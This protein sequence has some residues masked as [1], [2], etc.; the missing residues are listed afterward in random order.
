MKRIKFI[1]LSLI[2]V[3]NTVHSQA[4]KIDIQNG[5][6]ITIDGN[7]GFVKFRL[8]QNADEFL[9]KSY[10][11]NVTKTQNKICFDIND[12]SIPVKSYTSNNK[13]ALRDFLKMME[14]DK[15]KTMEIILNYI[16]IP[17][18]L[19]KNHSGNAVLNFK[20]KGISKKYIMPVYYS[21]DRDIYTFKSVK[22]INIKDFGLEAPDMIL[23]MVK[24]N[25][26]INIGFNLV[27]KISTV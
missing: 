5:S 2:V 12:V 27:L 21:K 1:I 8:Y 3:F 16:E 17:Q 15:Y 14:P 22:Q 11:L 10:L 26:L 23:G 4:L 13:M 6:S 20:I 19:N 25:D 24:V 18:D 9:K 7:A